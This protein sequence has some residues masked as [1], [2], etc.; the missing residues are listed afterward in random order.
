LGSYGPRNPPSWWGGPQAAFIEALLDGKP[1]DIH[2]DGC[3]QRSFTYV[4]D[5]VDGILAA[6]STPALRGEVLNIGAAEPIRIIDLA[7]LVQNLLRIAPPLRARFVAYESFPG[8]YQDVRE[9]E[10]DVEKARALL[11]F[12]ARVSLTEGLKQTIEWHREN[13]EETRRASR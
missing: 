11:G 3:Q 6:L 2:G 12:R 10:P 13:R 1:M 4:S 5:T 9:R 7:A 8:R